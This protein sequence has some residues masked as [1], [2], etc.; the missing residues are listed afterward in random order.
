ML[1][2]RGDQYNNIDNFTNLISEI[3][4]LTTKLI[5]RMYYLRNLRVVKKSY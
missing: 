4:E 2:S 1:S 5:K 3:Y